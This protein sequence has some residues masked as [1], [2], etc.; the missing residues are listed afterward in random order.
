MKSGGIKG[1]LFLL[2]TFMIIFAIG[3]GGFSFYALNKTQQQAKENV[4]TINE[5]IILVDNSRKAQVTFKKQ[6]QAWKD[7]L[8][9][10][11]DETQHNTYFNQ[12]KNYNEEVIN[13]L[14]SL[15][16][17]MNS[18][19]IDTSSVDKVSA[20]INQLEE[21][22]INAMKNYDP[23]NKEG[24]KIIDALVK[25]KDKAP[26]NDMDSLIEA[27][28]NKSATQIKNMNLEAEA[29]NR[30]LDIYLVSIIIISIL[31]VALLTLI[32]LRTYKSIE[33]FIKQFKDLMEKAEDG[34]LTV[35]G[36]A[37]SGNELGELTI[38]FNQFIK[39]IRTL[40]LETKDMSYLL[41]SSSNDIL[42]NSDETVKTSH[43]I[44]ETISQVA[45]GATKQS[46]L[47]NEGNDMVTRVTKD[48]NKVTEATKYM[49]KLAMETDNVLTEGIS[50]IKIQNEKMKDS[51]DTTK[52]VSEAILNLSSQS[53]KIAEFV[54]I[55]NGITSQTNLLALNA[56]IEAARAG[57]AGKGF[58]VVAEEIRK[59][60]ESSSSFTT[61][62]EELIKAIQSG[63]NE[64]VS[65]MEKF[66]KT[67]EEQI[68][69]IKN[70]EGVFWQIKDSTAKVA[71][72]VIDVSNNTQTIDE[73]SLLL[74]KAIHNI[75]VVVEQNAAAS[76]EVAASTEEQVSSVDEIS[77]LIDDLSKSS[78]KLKHFL[79]KYKVQ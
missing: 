43:Q 37:F 39:N 71:N 24:Y 10:G 25:G 79:D 29:R 63:V 70:T 16:K 61:Q 11:M 52:E 14:D 65:K 55:I 57:E 32:T 21:D 17:S 26:T 66:E 58:A 22:Y 72:Q 19:G 73:N 59:L 77:M 78:D 45:E 13:E 67:M 49:K 62:I 23:S 1:N 76:E 36:K 53:S 2:V 38:R 9:R 3:L 33:M 27:I 15:K 68:D 7:L 20:E 35:E 12:F 42:Q 74:E 60:A 47:A 64:T 54:E 6:V 31:I 4:D 50:S 40:I 56:S 5:Y 8:L 46:V 75:Y 41:A 28:R 51:K 34:D 48:L 44:A 69:A 30:R 18:L